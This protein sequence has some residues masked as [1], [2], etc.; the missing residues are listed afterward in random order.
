M[1]KLVIALCVLAM[2]FSLVACAS[3]PAANP[4]QPSDSSSQNSSPAQS[5]TV[6]KV[7]YMGPMTGNGAQYGER[8]KA[9]Y[10]FAIEEINASGMLDGKMQIQYFDDQ[11]R[12]Q[13][14][15]NRC[16]QNCFGR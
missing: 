4:S 2:V 11:E 6:Y 10:D 12:C 5:D 7:A 8:N 14:G 16:Q 9:V 13:R 15:G 3:S 1:K